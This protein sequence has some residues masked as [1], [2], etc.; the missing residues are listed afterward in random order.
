VSKRFPGALI[1]ALTACNEPVGNEE[2]VVERRISPVMANAA[3]TQWTAD[4]HVWLVQGR[5]ATKLIVLLP[6]TNGAPANGREI[7]RVAAEQ[8]YRVIGLMYPDDRAV[9]SECAGDPTPDCMELMRQ[10]I[11]QGGDVSPH[12]MVDATNSI[13][14]RLVDLLELLHADYPGENWDA[15]LAGGSPKWDVIAVGGL[16]QGGGHAAW[17]ARHR[18]V[19]RVVMFGAPADGYSG[20]VAPWMQLGATPSD[21]YYG[22]RH[23]R[24]PFTSITPNWLA[25]GMGSFAAA[26]VV[27]AA[28]TDFGGSHMLVTG[29]LP[30]TGTFDHAH[31]SVYADG[32]VPRSSGRP[33]FDAAWRYLLGRP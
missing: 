5:A 7:G 10:E 2:G 6:G 20:Q 33:V 29:L 12:A 21:R 18:R 17:I 15:F 1:L 25:L 19:P 3:I 27:D 26:K 16:S 31:P 9:V 28:T 32:A 4:H 14:G 23:E 11:V 13:D 24:D 8:G 22:F 30:A